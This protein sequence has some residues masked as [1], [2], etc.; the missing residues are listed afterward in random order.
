[1]VTDNSVLII[2]GGL[3][4]ATLAWQLRRRGW[5]PRVIDSPAPGHATTV[6][7]GLITPVTGKK[8]KPEPDFATLLAT[9]SAHYRD[10][11]ASV[12]QA[13]LLARPA[14]RRLDT[15]Q[16]QVAWASADASLRALA[17]PCESPSGLCNAANDPIVRMP[18]AARLDTQRY[19]Q[20]VRQNL[21]QDWID[22]TVQDTAVTA[23][24]NAVQVPALNLS[25]QFVVFCRGWRDHDNLWFSELQWRPAKGQLI[26]VKAPTL[27]IGTTTLHGNGL[28]L[29]QD[30]DDTYLAG[31]TYSWD[32]F[33]AGP[34]DADT[35]Q[36]TEQLRGLIHCDYTLLEAQVGVRPIVAGRKPVAGISNRHARVWLL[37]GLGSKGALY[38]PTVA[39]HLVAAM[40]D[41][42]PIPAAFDVSARMTT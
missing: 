28:W 31:A 37:N 7:A 35:Q 30:D 17:E 4:G 21:G 6:A 34:T 25:G 42:Q 3:A 13:L 23:D 1:M 10:V 19:L 32:Q 38:A 18:D 24:A 39:Q 15:A 33:E 29:T 16:A 8:L 14:I 41:R 20:A 36:L 40:L 27:D 26:R 9:A 12:D 5:R 2:G 22:A 11:A